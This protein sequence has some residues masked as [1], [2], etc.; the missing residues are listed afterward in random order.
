MQK[1]MTDK[2]KFMAYVLNREFG[3]TMTSISQLMKVSQ[4]LISTSVKEVEYW[5]TIKN[6][7]QEL[8]EAKQLIEAQG[9]SL[10]SSPILYIE[11]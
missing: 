7:T 9:I 8:N 5:K 3:Y 1:K 2:H 4:S 11:D 10:P 6:L